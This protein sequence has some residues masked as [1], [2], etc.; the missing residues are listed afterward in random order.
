MDLLSDCDGTEPK[1]SEICSEES[2]TSDLVEELGIKVDSEVET[3]GGDCAVFSFGDTSKEPKEEEEGT[4]SIESEDVSVTNQQIQRFPTNVR[5]SESLLS[6]GISNEETGMTST[7]IVVDYEGLSGREN[8]D[9]EMITTTERA[10]PDVAVSEASDKATVLTLATGVDMG[11]AMPGYCTSS[12]SSMDTVGNTDD[13]EQ[14]AT[15]VT[16]LPVN[17]IQAIDSFNDSS[18]QREIKL[19]LLKETEQWDVVESGQ[20]QE[21]TAIKALDCT[22]KCDM[23]GPETSVTASQSQTLHQAVDDMT[24]K[25]G[26]ADVEDSQPKTDAADVSSMLEN[27]VTVTT[28]HSAESP[29]D[30]SIGTEEAMLKS[31]T[32]LLQPVHTP[33][34]EQDT[35]E[36]CTLSDDSQTTVRS[37]SAD[38]NGSGPCFIAETEQCNIVESGQ[39]QDGTAKSTLDCAETRDSGET[40]VS[41]L[42]SESMDQCM[43]STGFI[44]EGEN[45][46]IKADIPVCSSNDYVKEEMDTVIAAAPSPQGLLD[47]ATPSLVCSEEEPGEVAKQAPVECDGVEASSE[48]LKVSRANSLHPIAEESLLSGDSKSDNAPTSSESEAFSVPSDSEKTSHPQEESIGKG[49]NQPSSIGDC[50][51]EHIAAALVNAVVD[52]TA[53]LCMKMVNAGSAMPENDCTQG[54]SVQQPDLL[55]TNEDYEQDTGEIVHVFKEDDSGLDLSVNMEDTQCPSLSDTEIVLGKVCP[56]F[57]LCVHIAV[58]CITK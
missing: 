27:E 19:C 17:E 2:G 15:T 23:K 48:V 35:G 9:K 7:G 21:C 13:S 54:S 11:Q 3:L 37:V 12:A 24:A 45:V 58:E 56:R 57:S 8:L 53:K 32:G 1:C 50:S 34:S 14:K 36:V 4:K 43:A 47:T 29:E 49:M 28:S 51:I 40:D 5:A 44:A 55:K 25:E 38:H 18:C 20:S 22:E 46:V 26:N 39:S 33:T 30:P 16:L 31:C 42:Q 10:T 6:C 41:A 52:S